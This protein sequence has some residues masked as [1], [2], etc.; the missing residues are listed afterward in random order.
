MTNMGFKMGR[1]KQFIEESWV[2]SREN[3]NRKPLHLNK[4]HGFPVDAHLKQANVVEMPPPSSNSALR[5]IH[6]TFPV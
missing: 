1:F 5:Q 2:G 3:L 4:C 6:H